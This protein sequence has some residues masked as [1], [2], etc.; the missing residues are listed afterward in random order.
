V[1]FSKF[2]A[3]CYD[4]I[5]STK[6]YDGES[7]RMLK[8][9]ETRYDQKSINK[10]LDFGC[11]TGIHLNS[12][13]NQ[14]LQLHGYDRNEYMLEIAQRKYPELSLTSD[15]D[16]I[17]EDLDLIYS[18][19]D[20]INY[21]VTDAEVEIFFLAL[22]TKLRK[23]G[24]IVVDGWYFPGVAQDPPVERE[25]EVIFENAVITRRVAPKTLDNYRTTLLDISLED[26]SNSKI[27]THESHFMRAFDA[28]ELEEIA[29]NCG[30]G[31][32]SFRDG[33]N[34]DEE[35]KVDSWRFVMFAEK[36]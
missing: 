21:Q 31:V 15:Y 9:L 4:Q 6:S 34:W 7:Q 22:A 27:I 32:I 3:E 2:Y 29:R 25:R 33:R 20:V 23:G 13:K 28:K 17:P 10:V 16:K 30:F 14:N 26:K 19:F 8:F 24:I 35:L 18:L 5:H 1:I 11:G 36:D 12:L